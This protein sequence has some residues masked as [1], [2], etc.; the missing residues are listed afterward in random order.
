MK[1]SIVTPTYFRFKELPAYFESI[2]NQTRLPLEVIL[3]DG[4]STEEI[5]SEN[6]IRE[7]QNQS[8]LSIKY[9][10]Q[11][12]GTAIQRNYGIMASQGDIILFLDD[13][14]RIHPNFIESLIKPFLNDHKNIIGGITGYRENCYFDMAKSTRWKW[15]RRLNLLTEFTPGRYDYNCGYPINNHGKEPFIGIREV[16]FMTTACTAYRSHILKNEIQFDPFFKGYGILEDAH[17]S[18]SIKKKGYTLLQCGDARCIELSAPS[19]RSNRKIIGE[20][21][22]V[23]YYYV[24]KSICGPLSASQ[25]FRFFKFQTFEIIRA[26]GDILRFRNKESM[27][28]FMG[29]LVGIQKCIHPKF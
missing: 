11:Q 20:R 23:N 29:K 4:A 12:G 28:F 10:R 1:V 7:Y 8:K 26:F 17:L 14:V 3:V 18:L 24:F 13:D 25:K 21:T 2:E 5:R 22:V 6:F 16:D 9:Y 15:Y 27:D 19:G